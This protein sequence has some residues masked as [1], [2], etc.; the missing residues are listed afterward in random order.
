MQIAKSWI[1]NPKILLNYPI[2]GWRCE[3]DFNLLLALSN[4]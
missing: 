2:E 1:G 4:Q 3:R